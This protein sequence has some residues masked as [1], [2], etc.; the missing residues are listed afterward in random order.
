[1]KKIIVP[2]T[3]LIISSMAYADMRDRFH[4]LDRLADQTEVQKN[5]KSRPHTS[6]GSGINNQINK[7]IKT[8]LGSNIQNSGQNFNQGPTGFKDNHIEPQTNPA[9]PFNTPQTMTEPTLPE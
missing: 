8:P 3:I 6:D 4:E 5:I 9:N 7:D 2:L 1:M